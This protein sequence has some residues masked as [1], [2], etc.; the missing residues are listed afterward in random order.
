MT[1]P[2]SPPLLSTHNLTKRYGAEFAN[3]AIT[4]DFHLG[5]IHAIIGENGAG[6]STLMKMLFGL[7]QPTE[8][9]IIYRGKP[10]TV[11]SPQVAKSLRIAM[12]HQHFMLAE[13][14]TIEDHLRLEVNSRNRNWWVGPHHRFSKKISE[15]QDLL[16]LNVKMDAKVNQ[17]SVVQ[18]QKLEILKTLFFDPDFLIFDEPTAVLP[19]DEVREFYELIVKLKSRPTSIVVITHKLKEV[20]AHADEV[21]VLRR[22]E[23]KF[24]ASVP[25]TSV[26]ELAR[27]MV[28]DSTLSHDAIAVGHSP[29]SRPNS[30]IT[31]PKLTA[32]NDSAQS[33]QPILR[34]ENF[35][36]T[37][38]GVHPPLK[39]VTLTVNA[40]EIVAFAGVE[41]N[42][43]TDL[44]KCVLFPEVC[45][46]GHAQGKIHLLDHILVE[47]GKAHWRHADVRRLPVGWVGEDRLRESAIAEFDL[48]DHFRLL[49]HHRAHLQLQS[50]KTE[51][52]THAQS[53]FDIRPLN[54]N[55]K[56]GEFSGG[57]QQKWVIARETSHSPK[58]LIAAHP[59][60]GVDFAAEKRILDAFRDLRAKG[61]GVIFLS[62]DLDEVCN[63]ADR[64]FVFFK[65]QVI[66]KF[67]P[68]YSRDRL[69]EAM[70]GHI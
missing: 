64:I 30:P 14:L 22:G 34:F 50:L 2:T 38:A 28:G 37:D 25:K 60:R 61:H 32:S 56:I 11:S 15:L 52:F 46:A 47:D 13:N 10:I 67:A 43:Q 54:L 23:I 9:E 45:D 31:P 20:L 4:V 24:H 57:N 35:S 16:R 8:G 18:K 39:N 66:A 1:E 40:G 21:T 62:S 6:K 19:P 5:K 26:Q 63:L 59:T 41:D 3:R 29:S 17:L 36:L 49:P 55:L 33:S 7:E 27:Y 12:V 69:G 65:G 42:G 53:T 70:G 58:L 48:S 51:T 44:I 68:P